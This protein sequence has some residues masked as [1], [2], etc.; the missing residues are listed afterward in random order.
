MLKNNL[1]K[2]SQKCGLSNRLQKKSKLIIELLE[3]CPIDLHEDKKNI[4]RSL[5]IEKINK[6]NDLEIHNKFSSSLEQWNN[7]EISIR[8]PCL[9][10]IDVQKFSKNYNWKGI[11]W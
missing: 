10:L 7:N 1:F 5:M 8:K 6:S 4:L 2:Y 11:N 3:K 9:G